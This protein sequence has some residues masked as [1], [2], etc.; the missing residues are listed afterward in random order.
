MKKLNSL[1]PV[2]V[3][4]FVNSLNITDTC[5]GKRTEP[6]EFKGHVYHA[7]LGMFGH[8]ETFQVV[9][10]IQHHGYGMEWNVLK[11]TLQDLLASYLLGKFSHDLWLKEAKCFSTQE[12]EN[13]SSEDW[14]IFDILEKEFIESL[15]C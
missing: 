5:E 12:L 9:R 13:F 1:N 6:F 7:I 10:D 4:E 15:C 11:H 2:E 3:V 8:G 14:K